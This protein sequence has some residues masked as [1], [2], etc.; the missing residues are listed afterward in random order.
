MDLTDVRKI[1]FR[2][3][4]ETAGAVLTTDLAF[5]D[6]RER[7]TEPACCPQPRVGHATGVPAGAH[8]HPAPPRTVATNGKT[9][10]L[11][12]VISVGRLVRVRRA[13]SQT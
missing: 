8:E 4:V 7:S 6:P 2:H 5:T 12:L 9:R 13:Y 10:Y 1:T 11:L 3:N